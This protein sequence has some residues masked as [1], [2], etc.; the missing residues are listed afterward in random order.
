M[1]ASL[2]LGGYDEFRFKPHDVN[3]NLDPRNRTPSVNLRGIT[4]SVSDLNNWTTPQPLLSMNQ[5]LT[6]II[7]T[8]TPYLWLPQSVCDRFAAKLNLQWNETLGVYVFSDGSQY[9]DYLQNS[10]LSF[11]FSVS[12]YDNLDNY[13][14][15]LALPGVVNITVPS[16]AFAQ[17]LRYPFN[18]VIGVTDS[19]VPYFPLKRAA[20]GGPYIIGRAFMQAAYMILKYETSSFSL[21]E[22]LFPANPATNISIV[23]IDH[24]PTSPYPS[25]VEPPPESGGLQT[26][27]IVGIAVAVA[28]AGGIGL[29]TWWCCRRRRK[30]RKA[31]KGGD[32]VEEMK[33]DTESIDSGSPR[34]P[35]R[36]MLSIIIRRRR[37][38]RPVIHEVD[39][40]HTQPVE[41]AADASHEVYELPVPLEPVELDSNDGGTDEATEFGTDNSQGLSP[42]ELA[43]RKLDRQLQG[44]SPVYA[45]ALPTA[46]MPEKMG[47]DV[48]PVAH[49][50]PSEEPSPASSPSYANTNSLPNSL[51]SPMTPHPGDW[52]NRHFD[53]PSP[54]T[55]APPFPSPH[56]PGNNSGANTSPLSPTSPHSL[57]S[58][59]TQIPSFERSNTPNVSPI[60]PGGPIIPPSPTYQ[61]TPIDPSRVVC[62]GPLPDNVQL[63][64]LQLA[65]PRLIT[66]DGRIINSRPSPVSPQSPLAPISAQS[67]HRRR[68][69]STLGSDFTVEEENRAQDISRHGSSG[70]QHHEQPK[71]EQ[72]TDDFPRS[73]RSMERIDGGS[74][75]VHV[76]QLADKRYSWENTR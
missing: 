3:F 14:Q 30:S 31:K 17:L 44:P 10:D 28:L 36:R 46:P 62:L 2:T 59:R 15:P 67:G 7:D 50:R 9:S 20:E 58:L 32:G 29:L 64:R 61:R 23:N 54:M 26:P 52:T 8:S 47:Q 39:G 75:L 57:H 51:P 27:Q 68:S 69:T 48:S 12:S 19:S 40:S 33:E 70:Q 22:A 56:F 13:A 63:P 16:A 45:S 37:S 5:S 72:G 6:A 1:P 38:K 4:V 66:P 53:L 74:E 21:H 55:V 49:Y 25:H 34:S 65:L 71:E 11:T 76:P 43:R 35:V 60:S 24:A 73:P 42:Y 18:N 41:F